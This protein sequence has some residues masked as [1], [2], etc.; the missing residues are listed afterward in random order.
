MS[1]LR[2]NSAQLDRLALFVE[3]CDEMA[4]YPFYAVRPQPSVQLDQGRGRVTY[5][6]GSGTE[7]RVAFYPFL[8]VWAKGAP[9]HWEAV[10]RFLI[11][12]GLPDQEHFSALEEMTAIRTE[13][14]RSDGL[15]NLGF[16]A[17]RLIDQWVEA[18]L[19]PTDSGDG[20]RTEFRDIVA[21]HGQAT[22]EYL[23]RHGVRWIGCH[24]QRL[25]SRSAKPALELA[26]KELDLAATIACRDLVQ[27]P[28]RQTLG[29]GGIIR[30]TDAADQVFDESIEEHF[31]R[32]LDEFD[33][34]VLRHLLPRLEATRAELLRA[35]LGTSEMA[36]LLERLGGR[37]EYSEAPLNV[38]HASRPE[39]FAGRS[40]SPGLSFTQLQGNIIITDQPS[41]ENVNRALDKLRLR[42]LRRA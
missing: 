31:A 23:V 27:V 29:N 3:A 26:R 21:A 4:I 2:L 9:A 11:E 25:S 20:A 22:V 37:L 13:I 41:V 18:M 19:I 10:A 15:C 40:D 32:L 12:A 34:N 39:G 1:P 17:G 30:C 35:V 5:S 8:R 38:P 6:L 28:R 7:F 42:L 16:P 14:A 33:F 36:A 24:L